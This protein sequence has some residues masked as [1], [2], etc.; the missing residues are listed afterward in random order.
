MKFAQVVFPI[1]VNSIFVYKIPLALKDKIKKGVLVRCPFRNVFLNGW[2][3]GVTN[4]VDLKG[5]D[6]KEIKEVLYTE[7]LFSE[8]LYELAEWI[9]KY[10]CAEMG[11][12][13]NVMCFTKNKVPKYSYKK[14]VVF[15]KGSSVVNKKIDRALK[16][17]KREKIYSYGGFLKKF[18]LTE[19]IMKNLIVEKCIFV[20]KCPSSLKSARIKEFLPK[21][22]LPVYFELNEEQ[23]K[24]YNK[25]LDFLREDWRFQVFLLFGVTGSG[26][27]EIY[28]H[29]I[30]ESIKKGS[31]LYL[32]PEITLIPQVVKYLKNKF[33]DIVDWYHSLRTF[34][35]KSF[36][37]E[38]IKNGNIKILVGTRSAVFAPFDDLRLIIVD[39]EHSSSYKSESIVY[40]NARDVAI[41][42]GYLKNIPVILGSATPSVE[43]FYNSERGKFKKVVLTRRYN[44]T[45][46]P[47]IKI[48][49]VKNCLFDFD[50]EAF[51]SGIL[52]EKIFKTL[53]KKKQVL[54]FLNRRGYSN[55][56]L[57]PKCNYVE[58]CINCEV[59]LTYHKKENK[60]ICHHCNYSKEVK[61]TCEKCNTKLLF[62]GSGTQRIE[63]KIKEIFSE[64]EVIRVD[65]DN[66][67]TEEK[68]KD[69]YEKI[70]KG[71]IDIIIGTQMITKGLDIPNLELVAVLNID[72]L[73]FLPDIRSNEHSFQMLI[74]VAGRAGRRREIG[75][76]Y[77]QTFLPEHFVFKTAIEQD[78][79][80]FFEREIVM[81]KRLNLPPFWKLIRI[82]II[83]KKEENVKKYSEKI[84]NILLE[85]FFKKNK[86]VIVLGPAPCVLYRLEKK[87]RY[88]ILVKYRKF[89]IIKEMTSLFFSIKKLSS[90]VKI[91]IDV[92]PVN[93]L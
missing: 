63:E 27:T 75:E 18:K 8:D 26:K 31:V 10:Y 87:Y 9:N 56:L 89:G 71:D 62:I 58:K 28:S 60:L 53:K 81:R 17:L 36:V 72:D 48:I 64:Y 80:K 41:Y 47:K 30:S 85:E 52:K 65:S 84:K 79:R 13:Y 51:L 24:A 92:D 38:S 15:N 78:Y 25:I 11:M 14:Y 39:E 46:L 83:G 1:K 40:Y 54:L 23:K 59:S 3:I 77:I 49:D 45:S 66:I 7:S 21:S 73:L 5:R 29:L 19:K 55:Y 70:K 57:C 61:Y 22:H 69:V 42:R 32:V 37:F 33:G 16:F 12:I 68:W 20:L 93:F 90:K 88:Q 91:L 2:V 4:K 50:E 67:T 74:Q 35:E 44:L 76:V 82:I 43:S 86:E 34:S 6:I